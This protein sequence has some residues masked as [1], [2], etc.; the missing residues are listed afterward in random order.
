[1]LLLLQLQHEHATAK[2]NS[3]LTTDLHSHASHHARRQ[4]TSCKRAA[5]KHMCTHPIDAAQPFDASVGITMPDDD[6]PAD[7]TPARARV[8]QHH[9]QR[10]LDERNNARAY[11]P[12]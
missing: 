4:L 2:F 10:H 11:I 12:A 7:S 5:C 9:G 1:M 3:S 8:D 6:T